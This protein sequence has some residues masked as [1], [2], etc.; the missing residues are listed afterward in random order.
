[1]VT[2]QMTQTAEDDYLALLNDVY[3]K[4]IDAALQLDAR[5]DTLM[6]NLGRFKHFCPPTKRF[7]KFRRCV[8]T[9]TISLVYEVG[10][11]SITIISVFD[12]RSNSP[13]Y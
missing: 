5:M 12:N 6:E 3:Q 7:P 10:I 13:F 4:S 11:N 2:V 1:M 9:R 8:V